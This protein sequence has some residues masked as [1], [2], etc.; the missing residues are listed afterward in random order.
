MFKYEKITNEIRQN[1][2]DG[3]Y[4]NKRLPSKRELSLHYEVSVIT[5]NKVLAILKDEGIITIKHGSGIY[6]NDLNNYLLH[7]DYESKM[8]GFKTNSYRPSNLSLTYA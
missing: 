4:D 2:I 3:I 1:I 7:S 5:I 6:I 8:H